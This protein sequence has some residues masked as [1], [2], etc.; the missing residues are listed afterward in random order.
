MKILMTER[1]GGEWVNTFRSRRPIVQLGEWSVVNASPVCDMNTVRQRFS[2]T[3]NK[4]GLKACETRKASEAKEI[5]MDIVTDAGVL[6]SPDIPSEVLAD[7]Y[8]VN[9]E[10]NSLYVDELKHWADTFVKP[11]LRNWSSYTE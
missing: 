6:E 11:V 8:W 7:P 10:G 1:A 4:T 9:R 5:L 3:H 2:V